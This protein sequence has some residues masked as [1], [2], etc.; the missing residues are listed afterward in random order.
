MDPYFDF[1]NQLSWKQ[2]N[3]FPL[4]DQ[5]VFNYL[6]PKLEKEGKLKLEKEN[7]IIWSESSTAKELA[8]S[9]VKAGKKYPYLIH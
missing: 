4:V 2:K 5:S 8:V 3:L 9:D 6:L 7:Y 1:N